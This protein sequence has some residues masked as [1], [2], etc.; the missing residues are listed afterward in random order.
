MKVVFVSASA[1]EKDGAQM[2]SLRVVEQLKYLN[3]SAYDI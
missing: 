1:K 3:G 2:P